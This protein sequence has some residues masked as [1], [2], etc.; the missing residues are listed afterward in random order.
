[1]RILL[2]ADPI[3]PVPPILYG[4][5]E[6]II[7]VLVLELRN[8]G[9]SVGLVAHGDS[10]V[11]ADV[12]FPWSATHPVKMPGHIANILTLRRAIAEFKPDILHSFSRLL[13]LLPFVFSNFPKVMTYERPPTAFT[14]RWSS[15][16]HGKSLFFTGCGEHLCRV[17]EGY[18]GRWQGVHNCIE[19]DKFTFRDNL[20]DDAPLVFLSRIEALKGAHTAIE[21]A[22]RTGR[23]LLIA[24]NHGDSGEEGRY[25]RQEI[26]PHLGKDGIEYVGEV[27]DVAKNSLL[28]QAA[29]M[30]VPIEWD[31]PFGIVFA[32][33]LACGT[34]VISSP[35]GALPEIVRDGVDGFLVDGVDAACLAVGRLSE[36]SRRDCR[37]R[38]EVNFSVPVIVQRYEDVYQSLVDKR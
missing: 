30:I 36:L 11:V 32:E 3:L 27:D 23:R 6:R 28:G 4:G 18:G 1:M 14:V 26:L 19:I 10:T 25:W 17:G 12:F 5:T 34:P 33:S 15:R 31:E 24:G 35:R 7:N 38:A 13:Y 29:A 37:M 2:T 22:R 20:P 9:H 21:V 16:L 8:R